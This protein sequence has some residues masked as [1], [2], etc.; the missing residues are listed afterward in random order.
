M[1][2]AVQGTAR[3][4]HV[5]NILARSDGGLVLL[6]MLVI[7]GVSGWLAGQITRRRGFGILRN[8]IIGLLGS[9]L[10]GLLFNLL[11]VS[12]YSLLGHLVM[13]TVGAL[14]LLYLINVIA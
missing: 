13:A 3:V 6:M 14:V 10:G 12:A 7:G 4:I 9:L 5:G 11:G 2:Q 1:P 8:V